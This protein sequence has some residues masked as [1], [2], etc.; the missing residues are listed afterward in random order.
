MG[1]LAGCVYYFILY[2]KSWAKHGPIDGKARAS[3]ILRTSPS[4]F[5]N[6]AV[7]ETWVPSNITGKAVPE[8]RVLPSIWHASPSPVAGKVVPETWV[9]SNV[10]GK[11]VPETRVPPSVASTSSWPWFPAEDSRKGSF[12]VVRGK[13]SGAAVKWP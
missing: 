5:A 8:M 6:K 4:S 11:A 12:I 10:A 13:S 3:G 2:Y 9:P 7:P 1:W